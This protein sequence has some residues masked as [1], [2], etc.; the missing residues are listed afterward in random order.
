MELNKLLVAF[1]L[2]AIVLFFMIGRNSNGSKLSKYNVDIKQTSVSGI[3]SGGYMAVQLSFVYSKN[4]VGAGVVAGG[5]YLCTQGN[6]ALATNCMMIPET[7]NVLGLNTE[8]VTLQNMGLIDPL[9]N[10]KHQK[11]YAYSGQKDKT[12]F[13][14]VVEKLVSQ[15]GDFGATVLADFTL[16]SGHAW[17][18]DN[19]GNACGATDSPYINNCGVNVPLKILQT[20]YGEL[21]PGVPM[22][23]ENLMQFDQTYYTSALESM[24]DTGYLYVPTSCQKGAKCTIHVALHGCEMNLS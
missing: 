3:S 2:I 10:L 24:E 11:I 12:V 17:I 22:V 21:K 16:P 19:Y 13:K 18:T 5:P 7:I 9:S 14:G 15:Y 23:K 4:F 8:A 20:I 1:F 6:V